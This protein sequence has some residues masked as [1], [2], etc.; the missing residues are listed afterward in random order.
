MFVIVF[1]KKSFF[2]NGSSIHL[3]L[4]LIST[5]SATVYSFVRQFTRDDALILKLHAHY[6]VGTLRGVNI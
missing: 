3:M 6:S 4:Y 5:P 1:M 2:F